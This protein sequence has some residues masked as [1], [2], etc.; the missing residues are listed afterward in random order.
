MAD[1]SWNGYEYN[2]LF[3]SEGDGQ[4]ADVARPAGA[5]CIRDSRGVAI[6]DFD[7]DGRLDIAINNNNAE[8]FIYRNAYEGAGEWLG[9]RLIGKKS[10]RDAIGASVTLTVNG[11][12]M[13]RFVEA[14]SGYASQGQTTIHMGLGV[15]AQLERLE[16]R[17]PSGQHDTF[18]KAVLDREIRLGSLVTL[19]EG[20]PLSDSSPRPE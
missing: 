10:N 14:G 4:Y 2:C 11:K 15:D 9:F 8:P 12:A 5:D 19:V 7:R 13:T 18:E 16:V 6:A 20:E 1:N 17:W 3:A